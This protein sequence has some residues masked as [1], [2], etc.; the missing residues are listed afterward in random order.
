MRANRFLVDIHW[1]GNFGSGRYVISGSF[2]WRI[3]E[4]IGTKEIVSFASNL[5]G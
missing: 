4:G 5:P 1:K 2:G 3:E